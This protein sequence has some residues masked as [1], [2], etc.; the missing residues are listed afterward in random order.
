MLFNKEKKIPQNIP[1]Q[2]TQYQRLIDAIHIDENEPFTTVTSHWVGWTSLF[3]IEW[4][5]YIVGLFCVIVVFIMYNVFPFHMLGEIMNDPQVLMAIKNHQDLHSFEIAIKTT[6]LLCG[7]LF[8]LLGM[9]QHK[10]RKRNVLLFDR[11]RQLLQVKQL[12][13][14]HHRDLTTMGSVLP[15][16]NHKTAE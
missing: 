7:L 12:L 2:I 15:D 4:I 6:L 13:E 3:I 5:C 10:I 14:T 1:E 8:I 9:Q 16:E 11:T